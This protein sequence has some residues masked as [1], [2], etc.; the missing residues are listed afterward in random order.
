MTIKEQYETAKQAYANWGIDVDAALE[1]LK[2]VPI[3]IHCWQ[4]DDIGGFE[5]NK[6]ELS[7]GIDITGN[8]PGKATTPEEL[9]MDLEKA[10]S[11]IPG[12]HRVNLHAIYAETNGE[13]V[14]RDQLEPKHFENWLNWAKE[15]GLG[16]DFNPTLFSHEK[17][18]DGLTLS[19]PNEEIREFWI[20]HC[21][22]SRKI[23]EYFGR[24]LGNPCLT[25]IW[26]PDGYKDIPSDRLTP[27]K[28]LKESLDRIFTAE[29]DE[30]CNWDAVESKVFG[31]GS[32][33][34]VVGS[35][36]FYL[37]YALKNNKI[38]LV[39]TGH[40]HPTETVS[41]KISSMLLYSDKLAL[42]VSRP[43]RWDSDHVVI[44]DDELREIA[45]EIVR[46]DALNQ[47]II[48][49]DFF[50]ASINRVAAWT[51]GTRNMIKALLYALLVPNDH[52]KELQEKG[53]FT[54]RLALMEEFKTYPFGA[55]WDYYCEKMN[56]P[57]KERWL[58]QVKEYER[59]VLGKR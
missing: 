16:L 52:L 50:D 9:R 21:I 31:I 46:N 42:H 25:N 26:I 6:S 22:A 10:L 51:I 34:Y 35:H 12:K 45:L 24:E 4:G 29:V 55:I 36:E 17:A 1:T 48:G 13:A 18:A 23:G 37:G 40:Y 41:N 54:E 5:V 43:V 49:L 14:E 44:L 8:Y 7:G 38:C 11:L 59:D 53:D 19:H 47:V 3:S 28:R 15:N 33:S 57:V 20:D 32:E 56:V 58:T 39:D 27:R 30:T 2:K